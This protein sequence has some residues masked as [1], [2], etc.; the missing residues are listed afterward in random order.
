MKSDNFHG[1]HHIVRQ[2]AETLGVQ[3]DSACG[4]CETRPDGT[5]TIGAVIV[6]DDGH[7]RAVPMIDATPAEVTTLLTQAIGV[8]IA[9]RRNATNWAYCTGL[10][11]VTALAWPRAAVLA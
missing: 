1:R 10:G 6:N 7:V 3:L 9:G 5:T 4:H 2:A 8:H 11:W